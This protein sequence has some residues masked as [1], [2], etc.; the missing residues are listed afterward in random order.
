MSQVETIRGPVDADAL[1]ATLMHEHIFVK[2]PELEENYPNPEWSEEGAQQKARDGMKLL[3]EKGIETVVDLTVMGLGRSI[4][5]IQRLAE[6]VDVN[7]IVATGYYTA[8]D[9]PAYFQ[10]H[11]P[12]RRVDVPEPLDAMFLTDI[13]KGIA[14]TGVKAAIIKVVTD[15]FGITPDVERVL[16][17]A[18]H[19]QLETGVPISTHTNAAMQTGRL[20]QEFFRKQSV[21]LERVIIGHSGDTT[22]LDYLKELMD[23]GSTLGMDRFG[24]DSL[25]SE[26]DR[27]ATVVALCEQGYAEKITLS[28]DAG[29]FSIN[30][31]PSHRPP[32][33]THFTVSDRILPALR[34]RGV[35]D[36]TIEQIMVRNPARLLPPR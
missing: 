9:L 32:E 10:T 22:D 36:D 29:F 6:A 31:E 12:G 16:R 35:S 17:S 11:G 15:E 26:Q 21:D 18:A 19:A 1:G 20:Q 27:I 3:L 13:Q 14:D 23:N 2:N 34:E 25:L 5:R 28:H 33:W 30:T 4:P 24:I 8:K 7:I